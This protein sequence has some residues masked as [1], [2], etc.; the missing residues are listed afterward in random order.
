MPARHY[1]LTTKFA[2]C[3]NT[4]LETSRFQYLYRGQP[5]T[6]PFLDEALKA[7]SFDADFVLFD[8]VPGSD[9]FRTLTAVYKFQGIEE[10]RDAG[11]HHGNAK[12]D[13]VLERSRDFDRPIPFGQGSPLWERLETTRGKKTT[14]FYN[15]GR[16]LL[17]LDDEDFD[18]IIAWSSDALDTAEP[19][20]EDEPAPAPGV[21]LRAESELHAY[22]SDNLDVIENGLRPFDPENYIEY[23]TDDGGRIDLLCRDIEDNVVV[24]EL[25]RG[26]ADDEVIGQLARY[27]GWAREVLGDDG[28]IRGVI[29]A[30][31]VSQRLRRAASVVP[32]V[33]LVSYSV[34]FRLQQVE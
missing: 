13:L 19:L 20:I 26:K 10:D 34:E 5:D 2:A 1:I 6:G 9:T 22:L 32:N 31:V 24:V 28:T 30:N 8:R 14:T 25:K 23:R 12:F 11:L 21:G 33:R 16:M 18:A 15:A 3:L 7:G 27:M 29:I 4:L 17:P